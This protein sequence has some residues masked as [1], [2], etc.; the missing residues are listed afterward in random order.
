MIKFMEGNLFDTKANIIAH[1]VNCQGKMNSGVAKQ[2]REKYPLAYAGYK[3]LCSTISP[4][5]LLGQ[6]QIVPCDDKIIANVYAQN[7]YGYDGGKYTNVQAFI[8]AMNKL[9]N[10]AEQGN[11]SIA[12]PY[13][14]GCCRGGASWEEE[15]YVALQLLFEKS[16]VVLEIWKLPE[17]V[18]ENEL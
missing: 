9:V 10:V 5:R 12:V 15:I 18:N 11:L 17:G 14:I 2:I 16:K 3:T 4:E 7:N 6:L 8:S 13:K 1:Q